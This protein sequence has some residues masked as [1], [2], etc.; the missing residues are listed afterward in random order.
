MCN[1][2]NYTQIL[3]PWI[4]SSLIP[5]VGFLATAAEIVFAISLLIGFKTE[6]F[7]KLS[8]FLLLLFALSITFSI[9]IKGIF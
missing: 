1:F 8:G 9:G 5:T 6:L 7:V 3:N 2:L 4:P